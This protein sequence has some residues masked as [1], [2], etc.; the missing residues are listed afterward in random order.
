[1]RSRRLLAGLVAAA[2]ALALAGAATTARAADRPIAIV[3]FSFDPAIVTV[4]VGDSV[5]WANSDDAPH[6]STSE[7][8]AW[9]SGVLGEG[10][11]FQHTFNQAGLYPYFCGIHSGMRGA[12]LVGPRIYLPL[13]IR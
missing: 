5:T 9:D 10:G 13:V 8:A 7:T 11:T 6:T 12:V 1:M 3:N 4:E 2:S